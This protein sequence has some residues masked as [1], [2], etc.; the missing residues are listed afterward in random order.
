MLLYTE[1]A[2][3]EYIEVGWMHQLEGTGSLPVHCWEF[4]ILRLQ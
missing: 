4:E 1:A 3:L 2:M